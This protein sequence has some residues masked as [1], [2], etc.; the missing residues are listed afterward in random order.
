M[1]KELTRATF[2]VVLPGL[3]A[4]GVCGAAVG[5]G[6]VSQPLGIAAAIGVGLWVGVAVF[7]TRR[8]LKAKNI[9]SEPGGTA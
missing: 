2:K 8:R 9:A 7:Q 4:G 3:I 1:K 6:W 5:L